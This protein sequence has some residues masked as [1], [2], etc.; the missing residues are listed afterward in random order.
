MFNFD[1][2]FQELKD[3]VVEIAKRE[4][5]AFVREAA[6]D[7]TEFLEKVKN[8]LQTWTRQLAEGGLSQADFAFLVK[9]QK[10]VA[11]MKALTQA[12]LAAIRIQRIQEALIDLI[13]TAAGKIV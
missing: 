1:Q 7:G 2:F 6:D 9:G 4:A 11:A 5:T 8:N 10:D 13:I 12:G 3:G